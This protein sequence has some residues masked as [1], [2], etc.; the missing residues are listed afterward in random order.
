MTD[1]KTKI[2]IIDDVP[3][4]IYLL[5]EML[6]Q[7]EFESITA[8]SGKEGIRLAL[9]E[10]P[11]LIICD[12]MMPELS[13]YDVMKILRQN[14][15]TE[16]IPFVFLSA[17]ISASE[18]R[19][20]M[21]LGADDYLTKPVS[22]KDLI[23][24]IRT[25]LAK[26]DVID[27]RFE[28]LINSISYAL[29]HELQTPLTSILGYSEILIED[30]KSIEREDILDM[31]KNINSSAKRLNELIQKILLMT[32]LDMLAQDTEK[33]STLKQ[34]SICRVENILNLVAKEKA[35]YY[36][37]ESDLVIS[38]QPSAINFAESNFKIVC[39]EIIDNALKYSEKNTPV[40]IIGISLNN[41]YVISVMDSGRGMNENQ[42]AMIGN[43]MQFD[44]NK[45]EQQG[46]GL[47]LTISKKL[48]E[49]YG[50]KFK[51]ESVP[52]KQTI[53]RITLNRANNKKY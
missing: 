50:G 2:L 8:K 18:I 34:N 30:H 7:K 41:D 46:A 36:N 5:Q 14:P 21:N 31:A 10:N 16:T 42:I 33:F 13:G 52:Q 29:P 49:L 28:G 40:H 26:K 1:K 53:V 12:I 44:R 25:R 3:E 23:K 11:G 39:Q 35:I 43:F 45:F 47:G 27:K 22:G 17:K 20:G 9:S 32:K 48:T 38:V 19:E 6:D 37:R 24:T 4:N 51:I 15:V